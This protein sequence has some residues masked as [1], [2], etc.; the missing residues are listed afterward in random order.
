MSSGVMALSLGLLLLPVTGGLSDIS[1]V[2]HIPMPGQLQA[3]RYAFR[4]LFPL[5]I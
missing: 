5:F 3:L 4:V 1:Q 2:Y